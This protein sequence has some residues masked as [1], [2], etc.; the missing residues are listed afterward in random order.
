MTE[1]YLLKVTKDNLVIPRPE[2]VENG[3]VIEVTV[4]RVFVDDAMKKRIDEK[5]VIRIY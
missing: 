1:G 2:T 5:G 3:E 4:N